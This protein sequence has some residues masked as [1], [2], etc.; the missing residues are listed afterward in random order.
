[1]NGTIHHHEW[2]TQKRV[3]RD[4]TDF[5]TEARMLGLPC[6]SSEAC[7]LVRQQS[8]SPGGKDYNSDV[9]E[10]WVLDSLARSTR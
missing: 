8:V 1:M 2:Y 10:N 6:C 7:E 5:A 4:K 9:R 3:N